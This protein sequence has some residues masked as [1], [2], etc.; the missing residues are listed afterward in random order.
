[1]TDSLALTLANVDDDSRVSIKDATTIQLHLAEVI[2][3]TGDAKDAA[4]ANR[5][6]S[7]T[8][9]DVTSI[10]RYLAK[11]NDSGNKCG[12][13]TDGTSPTDPTQPTVSDTVPDTVPDTYPTT[14]SDVVVF[15]DNQRW[16]SVYCYA[17]GNGDTLGGWPGTKMQEVGTNDYGEK[18]FKISIPSG[19][20]GIIFS[21]G[22]GTQTV[23]ISYS[24]GV[25]GYYVSG[26]ENGKA[27]VGSW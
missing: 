9:K 19:T 26:W 10:Q 17:W 11:F 5:D 18:Q 7:V 6:N 25:T 15:S 4:D 13:Y 16:G 23:D 12:Q 3:L 1:M 2:T 27:T 24:G 21:N 22:N 8:V 14:S 20:T